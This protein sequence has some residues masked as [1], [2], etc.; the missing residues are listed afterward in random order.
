MR[1]FIGEG[2]S[3]SGDVPYVEG[4]ETKRL[5]EKDSRL[6]NYLNV[7]FDFR[8]GDLTGNDALNNIRLGLA[9]SSIRAS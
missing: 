6:M 9:D 2:L 4:R 7:G 3:L 1:F 5:S 8:L